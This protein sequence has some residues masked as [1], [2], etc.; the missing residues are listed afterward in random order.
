[1]TDERKGSLTAS[2]STWAEARRRVIQPTEAKSVAARS[3]RPLE[4]ATERT[5]CRILARLFSDRRPATANG[6]LTRRG[7]RSSTPCRR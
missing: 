1:M 7:T 5:S 2:A 6:V 3:W 4:A